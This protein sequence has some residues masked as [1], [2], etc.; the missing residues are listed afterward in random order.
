MDYFS[1]LW[2]VNYLKYSQEHCFVID[3]NS[4]REIIDKCSNIGGYLPN[5][6]DT[7]QPRLNGTLFDRL[8]MH[9]FAEE[10]NDKPDDFQT[11]IISLIQKCLNLM[12][13]PLPVSIYEGF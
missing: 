6:E 9:S 2:S 1:F 3:R 12:V 5:Y 11:G 8:I 4:S 7:I 13:R 10:T